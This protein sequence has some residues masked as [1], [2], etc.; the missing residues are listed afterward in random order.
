MHC[1][2]GDARRISCSRLPREKSRVEFPFVIFAPFGGA[3]T[4]RCPSGLA[5]SDFLRQHDLVQVRRVH[6]SPPF[7]ERPCLS[8]ALM[9]RQSGDVM[10]K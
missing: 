5:P 4:G 1:T 10:T 2:S 7:G 3:V 9:A 6:L 8:A